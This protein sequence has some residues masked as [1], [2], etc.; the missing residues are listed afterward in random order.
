MTSIL[1]FEHPLS[2]G[3]KVRLLRIALGWRQCDL[4]HHAAITPA[5]VSALE[6][7]IDHNPRVLERVQGVLGME[8]DGGTREVSVK[9]TGTS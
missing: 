5:A 1:E 3:R 9:N 6:R 7:D 2:I 4:A 8:I